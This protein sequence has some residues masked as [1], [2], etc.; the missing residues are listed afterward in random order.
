V[1][2]CLT[3]WARRL[4]PWPIITS[5]GI[6]GGEKTCIFCARGGGGN[7]PEIEFDVLPLLYETNGRISGTLAT[8]PASIFGSM[9]PIV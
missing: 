8:S 7:L 5:S 1:T 6:W 3:I 9:W 2:G 4:F